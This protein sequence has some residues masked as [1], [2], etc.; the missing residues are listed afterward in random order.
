ML[1]PRLPWPLAARIL[2][3]LVAGQTTGGG[4]AIISTSRPGAESLTQ[5][6]APAHRDS[7][8]RPLSGLAGDAHR[9]LVPSIERNSASGVE[10]GLFC[11]GASSCILHHRVAEL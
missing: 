8:R 6:L 4:S 2:E 3:R 10:T 11:P 1:R 5:H 7:N 9:S